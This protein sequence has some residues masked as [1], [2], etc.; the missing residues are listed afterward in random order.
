MS[1]R[2][3]SEKKICCSFVRGL[4]FGFLE[5]TKASTMLKTSLRYCAFL[6]SDLIQ[7]WDWLFGRDVWII[8]ITLAEI[9]NLCETLGSS[10]KYFF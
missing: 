8:S 6:K 7:L 9:F 1:L 4:F 2:S 10:V 3:S 5:T